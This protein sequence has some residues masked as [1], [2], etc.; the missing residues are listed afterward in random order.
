MGKLVEDTFPKFYLQLL[1][2]IGASFRNHFTLNYSP[3]VVDS[4]LDF[5]E[6][7]RRFFVLEDV[8]DC[9]IE[10]AVEFRRFI[11]LVLGLR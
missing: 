3:I 1:Y 4:F 6:L 2:S 9:R 7:A 8:F 5:T 11:S 10:C